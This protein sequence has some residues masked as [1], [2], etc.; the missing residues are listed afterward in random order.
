MLRLDGMNPHAY[1]QLARLYLAQGRAAMAFS[2][3][4]DAVKL[5]PNDT[6][7]RIKLAS[8]YAAA[9]KVKEAQKEAA[10]VL[11]KGIPIAAQVPHGVPTRELDLRCRGCRRGTGHA[12][13][14][15]DG[16]DS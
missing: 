14:G 1:A 13:Q 11:E 7:L 4:A 12:R 3:L 6:D 9:G 5:N 15:E 2:A 8:I 10:L 16:G